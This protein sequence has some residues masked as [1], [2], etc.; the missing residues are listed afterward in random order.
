MNL[1]VYQMWFPVR[2]NKNSRNSNYIV[3]TDMNGPNK[4]H[5]YMLLCEASHS[6]ESYINKKRP[7]VKKLIGLL[8]GIMMTVRR[9]ET[10]TTSS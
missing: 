3:Q 10:E 1:G 7:E 8:L 9:V 6:V 4:C 5:A 2:D